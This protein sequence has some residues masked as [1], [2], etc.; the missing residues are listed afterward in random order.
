MHM[1]LPISYIFSRS[2]EIYLNLNEYMLEFYQ[3]R[4]KLGELES[5]QLTVKFLLLQ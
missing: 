1:E 4:L 2:L 3:L 5:L